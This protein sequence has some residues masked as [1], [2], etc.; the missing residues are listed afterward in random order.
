LSRTGAASR[1]LLG[2][3][4]TDETA[5]AGGRRPEVVIRAVNVT[6]SAEGAAPMVEQLLRVIDDPFGFVRRL[7][8]E[9]AP[10]VRARCS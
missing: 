6:L 9:V 8:D 1:S 10:V 7:G 2:Q 5:R 4:V 3:E